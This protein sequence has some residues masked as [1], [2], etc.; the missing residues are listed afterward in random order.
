MSRSVRIIGWSSALFSIVIIL[1]E[2]S[3][4]LNDPM[5]QL[6][7]V[8]TM[9]P[10]SKKEMALL[11]EL[12]LYGRIWSIYSILYFCVVLAGAIQFLQ[13]RA[14]GR[15]ILQ[16]ACWAGMMNAFIDSFLSYSLWRQMQAV[17]S[18]FTGAMGSISGYL[19]PLGMVTIVLG[20][21][22][23]IIPTIGMMVY[24]R[25]PELIALMR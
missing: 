25:K 22:L 15:R 24:L 20:F 2:V 23:W 6:K 12:F 10:Q 4:I 18:T 3:N 1:F 8:F 13:F 17:F 14:A 16:I 21:L 5:E 7:I 19:N 9:F 11:S